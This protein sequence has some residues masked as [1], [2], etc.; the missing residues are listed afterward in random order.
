M[1]KRLTGRFRAVRNA[2]RRAGNR[3]FGLSRAGLS[4]HRTAIERLMRE[5]RAGEVIFGRFHSGVTWR[6]IKPLLC[7]AARVTVQAEAN[8]NVGGRRYI[9]DLVVRCESTGRLLLVI[10]VWHTHAVSRV[11]RQAYQSACIPWIEVRAWSVIYWR[12]EHPIPILDWGGIA[13]VLSPCQHGLF[14]SAHLQIKPLQTRAKDSFSLRSTEWR[15]PNPRAV[16]SLPSD[17]IE[18]RHTGH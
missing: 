5:L 11:K 6:G 1:S 14:D 10:E 15:L 13:M 8:L 9:P 12:R 3:R 2:R 18:D 4:I 17:Y 16:F 7:N